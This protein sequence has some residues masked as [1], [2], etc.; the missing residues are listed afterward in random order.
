MIEFL[1]Y[2]CSVHVSTESSLSSMPDFLPE[3]D[4]EIQHNLPGTGVLIERML[5]NY[6]KGHRTYEL[7]IMLN[8]PILPNRIK[9]SE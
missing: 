6:E 2:G 1:S 8:F 7:Y 3:A 4:L 9:G 5:K